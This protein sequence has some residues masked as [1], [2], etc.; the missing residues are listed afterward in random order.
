M[1]VD[2]RDM[3]EHNGL[4]YYTIGQREVW[5]LVVKKVAIMLLGL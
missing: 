1:T 5:V 4:M 3:G 2:G